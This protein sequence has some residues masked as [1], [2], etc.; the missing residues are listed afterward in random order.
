RFRRLR[1]KLPDLGPVTS[2]LYRHAFT[3]DALVKGVGVAQVA[4]LLGHTSTDMVMRHY[5]KLGAHVG[6][7]CEAAAKATSD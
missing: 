3:T 2:Y 6:H 4:E 5:A 1:D 7:M